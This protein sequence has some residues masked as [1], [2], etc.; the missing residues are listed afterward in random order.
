MARATAKMFTTT[1]PT[2]GLWVERFMAGVNLGM[3]D[4][5]RPDAAISSCVMKLLQKYIEED[6]VRTAD[7][8]RRKFLMRAGVFCALSFLGGLQAEEVP[9]IVRKEFIALNKV[10]IERQVLPHVVIPLYGQFKNESN[11]PCCHV[12]NVTCKTKSVKEMEEQ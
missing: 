8:R 10:L 2:N 3:G 7:S 11:I 6:F 1:C 5:H 9:R 12:M 4:D